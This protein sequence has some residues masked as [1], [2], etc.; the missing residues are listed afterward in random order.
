[1]LP[2]QPTLIFR[3]VILGGVFWTKFEHF[4]TKIRIPNFKIQSLGWAKRKGVGG[5]EFLPAPTFQFQF[6]SA[7]AEFR[8]SETGA[9]PYF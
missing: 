7:T 9:P 4:L 8:A 3:N 6:F 1:M 5:K 2:R